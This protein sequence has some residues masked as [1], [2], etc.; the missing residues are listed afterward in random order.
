MPITYNVHSGVQLENDIRFI[1]DDNP[2]NPQIKAGGQMITDSDS[3]A[4]VYLLEDETGY[5]YVKFGQDVWPLLVTTLK[6]TKDPTLQYGEDELVLDMFREELEM[7]I[8]NIEGNENY[9]VEFSS[10]VEEA[11]NEIL[12]A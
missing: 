3:L 12:K 8:F 6:A 2:I 5:H 1:L 4:F 10:A 7:L 9:G 11:F